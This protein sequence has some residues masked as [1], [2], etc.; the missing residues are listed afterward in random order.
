M[1]LPRMS[2]PISI[3]LVERPAVAKLAKVSPMEIWI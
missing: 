2:W 3:G 1:N